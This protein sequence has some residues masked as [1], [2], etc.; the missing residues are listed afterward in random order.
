MRSQKS[1]S[2]EDIAASTKFISSQAKIWAPS[3]YKNGHDHFEHFLVKPETR[4]VVIQESDSWPHPQALSTFLPSNAQY[5]KLD[6]EDL[7][8]KLEAIDPELI[9]IPHTSQEFAK[10]AGLRRFIHD[11]YISKNYK[12][13]I[14]QYE[15]EH[16]IIS[17]S[18]VVIGMSA[19]ELERQREALMNHTSQ[20]RRTEFQHVAYENAKD[21]QTALASQNHPIPSNSRGVEAYKYYVLKNGELTYKHKR[22]D[23]SSIPWGKR[24]EIII[25][26]PHP[27]DAEIGCGGLIQRLEKIGNTPRVLNATSGARAPISLSD[28][29]NHPSPNPELIKQA[30]ANVDSNG[31]ITDLKLKSAIRNYESSKAL[32]H[33]AKGVTL[34]SLDLEFYLHKSEPTV[35][36]QKN[37]G[38]ELAK[39]LANS[40]HKDGHLVLFIPNPIDSHQTHRTVSKLFASEA[41]KLSK[42]FPDMEIDLVYYRTPW[43]GRHNLYLYTDHA[44]AS[45]SKAIIGA[46]RVSK[47]GKSGKGLMEQNELIKNKKALAFILSDRI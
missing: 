18:N 24:D 33:L 21:F 22:P 8:K 19:E 41:K 23:P 27:D 20:V 15:T 5:L 47:L 17:G 32:A 43:T 34:Q 25:A 29:N 45:R 1:Y 3:L 26:S 16:G 13:D 14:I 2:Q 12:I 37:V 28:L 9:M 10:L 11:Q 38:M 44:K 6:Q 40:V 36:D 31:L 4:T 30:K 7:H 39:G 42:R 46:E 35:N